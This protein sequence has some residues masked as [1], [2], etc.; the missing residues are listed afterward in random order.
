M[1]K[2]RT[3]HNAIKHETFYRLHTDQGMS[4]NEIALNSLYNPDKI[5]MQRIHQIIKEQGVL[6]Q[7]GRH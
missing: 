1:R 3:D 5:S 6:L 4:L 2:L 7:N